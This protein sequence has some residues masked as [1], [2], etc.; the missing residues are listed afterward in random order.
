MCFQSLQEYPKRDKDDAHETSKNVS[1]PYRNILSWTKR[2]QHVCRN[3]VSNPYRNILSIFVLMHLFYLCF[4]SNPYR[5]ILSHY[6]PVLQV[7]ELVCFQSLQEYP[8]L[9]WIIMYYKVL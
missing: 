9:L 2:L 6:V 4:V 7:G 5:N 8:K 3:M 1:N